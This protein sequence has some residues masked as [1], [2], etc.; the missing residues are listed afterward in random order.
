[1]IS[2]K[3]GY[4]EAISLITIVII[5]KVILILPQNIISSTGPA[6]WINTIYVSILAVLLAW[7]IVFLFKPFK[8]Q[9]IFHVCHFLGGNA[10]QI[11]VEFLYIISL[12]IVPIYVFK[13][14]AES[15]T[16]IYFATS[17]LL[18]IL[19][20]FLISSMIANHFPLKVLAK[21][22]T[23]LMI[24]SFLGIVLI[25][26]SSAKYFSFDRLFPIFGYG[27]K[28]TFITGLDSLFSF[29]GIGYLFLLYP[30]IDKT[31]K[32]KKISIIS[33]IISGIYLFFSVTCILLSVSFS[34][35]G[36]ESFSLYLLS[37]NVEFGRFLQRVD[38]VFILFW[39]ISI[40][41]YISFVIYFA[42]DIFKRLTKISDSRYINY[43]MHLLILAILLIPCTL[44]HFNAVVEKLFRFSIFGLI[45]ILSILILALANLKLRFT[46]KRKDFST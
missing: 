14:I 28:Q 2:E 16:T 41:L 46:N 24:V 20:F 7:L 26:I 4:I 21:A 9:D 31:E 37:R 3:L 32:F 22:N 30:L 44:A 33:I 1:M 34:T 19:L 13:N 38:A 10:L 35:K 29:S 42:I 39:I 23:I 25:L 36:G 43:S 45:Y 18:Y 6:S 17:P 12:L 11:L 40:I 15:L 8:G 27:Y 5:N